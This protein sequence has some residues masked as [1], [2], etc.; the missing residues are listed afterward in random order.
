MPNGYDLTVEEIEQ[1]IENQEEY[2]ALAFAFQHG[3]KVHSVMGNQ[4]AQ[5][6]PN[7]IALVA[8]LIKSISKS[9]DLHPAIIGHS[10][11]QL[12]VEDGDMMVF[13]YDEFLRQIED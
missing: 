8:S 7:Y 5:G 1:W 12:A 11:T 4:P 10:A 9:G 6:E 13:D 2:A 3:E